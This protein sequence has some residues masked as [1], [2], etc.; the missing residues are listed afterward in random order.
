MYPEV[1]RVSYTCQC[2]MLVAQKQSDSEPLPVSSIFKKFLALFCRVIYLQSAFRFVRN[3][4]DKSRA[5]RRS[6]RFEQ[7]M[8]AFTVIHIGMEGLTSNG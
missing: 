1:H 5:E 2:D 8:V 4:V 7:V 3:G 6:L